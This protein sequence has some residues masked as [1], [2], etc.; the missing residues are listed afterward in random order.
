MKHVVVIIK[1]NPSYIIYSYE[2]TV[3]EINF[4]VWETVSIHLKYR[5][6]NN[7]QSDHHR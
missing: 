7:D 1:S 6:K 2:L 4:K 5:I 3:K